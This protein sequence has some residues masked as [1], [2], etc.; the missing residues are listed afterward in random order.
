M[1]KRISVN[2]NVLVF[3][4][5]AALVGGC[6]YSP[7]GYTPIKDLVAAPASFEGKEVKLKGKVTDIT[8][9]PIV[10]LKSFVVQ[11]DTGEIAVIT[12]GTLPAVNDTVKLAGTVTSAVIFGGQAFGLHV[13]E[14]RRLN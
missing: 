11:D 6:D 12:Q 2:K 9:V 3:A 1:R 5:A 14:V 7:F 4:V 8:R 10:E 13:K